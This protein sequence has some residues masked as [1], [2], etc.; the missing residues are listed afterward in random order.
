[1]F[2]SGQ[3][4]VLVFTIHLN[5]LFLCFNLMFHI[6]LTFGFVLFKNEF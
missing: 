3:N 1:M 5:M 4:V 2:L 6:Y